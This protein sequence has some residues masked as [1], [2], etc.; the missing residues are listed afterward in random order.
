MT[1]FEIRERLSCLIQ[2]RELFKE[3]T[4]FQNREKN[5]A[6]QIVREKMEPL[7]G[8][9]VDS[10]KRVN[11]GSTI[12]REAPTRGGH[13]LRINLIRAI[14]REH[15]ISRFKLDDATPMKI[16]DS[17]ISRYRSRLW[18]EKIQLFNP[19]FWLYYFSEFLARIPVMF[20]EKAGCDTR[21]TEK[22]RG[23]KL[24]IVFIQLVVFYFVVKWI[25]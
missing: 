19:L 10:L 14:F 22:T 11:L 12:T 25:I 17:G 7:L 20:M 15:L 5:R 9:T 13:N 6:A 16:L 2:F 1:Y 8:F 3:Y 23:F 4:Q 18:K 21:Q 24:Y